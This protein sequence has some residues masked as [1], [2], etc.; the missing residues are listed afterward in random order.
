MSNLVG[1]C[2]GIIFKKFIINYLFKNQ[3]IKIKKDVESY[4]NII[5]NFT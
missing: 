2:Q 1:L 4:V 3:K 5:E